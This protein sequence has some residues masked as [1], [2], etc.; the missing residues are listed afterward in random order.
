ML[1]QIDQLG[2]LTGLESLCLCDQPLKSLQGIQAFS[3]L[4]YLNFSKCPIEDAAAVFTLTQLEE[5]VLFDSNIT[6]IQGI[7]NLTKLRRIG[8]NDSLV[9]DLSPLKDCDFAF[10][11]ENGGLWLFLGAIPCE[12]F[13]VLSTIEAFAQLS[14]D[15]H[16]AALW[17][18]YLAGRTVN[19]LDANHC[20]LRNDQI[21][22]I[23]AIPQLR[24]LQVC[25]NE[26]ITDLSPLLACPTLE[27]VVVNSYST[28]ALASIEGKAH[29]TIE[30]RD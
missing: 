3:E 12:D 10:A 24:E 8:I 20:N 29:F 4:R 5:L 16:D 13:S 30:Y 9:T 21:A 7:Q 1:E 18:P 19:I 22:A 28:E 27:K 2:K 17:L 26:Q 23:A 11:V 6:S 14:M 25:W 15:G